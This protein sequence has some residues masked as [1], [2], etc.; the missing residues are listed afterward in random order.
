M[1]NLQD[2]VPVLGDLPLLKDTWYSVELF[3]EHFVPEYNATLKFPLEED[4]F[5][6]GEEFEWVYG[7]QERFHLIEVAEGKDEWYQDDL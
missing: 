4:V 5:W 6:N 1:T 3:A 7:R 2:E